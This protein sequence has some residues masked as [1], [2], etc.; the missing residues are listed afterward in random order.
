MTALKINL[1]IV[2]LKGYFTKILDAALQIHTHKQTHTLTNEG[3]C[4]RV[5]TEW[6]G[7]VYAG[8][9]ELWNVSE[10]CREALGGKRVERRMPPLSHSLP[11]LILFHRS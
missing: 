10:V 8:V 3:V 11:L 9:K 5:W 6:V 7:F 1:K 4:W 2:A